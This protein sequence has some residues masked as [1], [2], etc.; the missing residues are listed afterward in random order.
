M[1][2][3]N[4]LPF[5]TLAQ[6]LPDVTSVLSGLTLLAGCQ[7]PAELQQALVIWLAELSD[8]ALVQLYLL[9]DSHSRLPLCC[10]WL[11]GA[12]SSDAER[13]GFT[14]PMLGYSLSQNAAL[15]MNELDSSLHSTS[16]L[17]AAPTPWRSL[18]CQPL[19]DCRQQVAGLLVLANRGRVINEALATQLAMISTIAM[20]QLKA[21]HQAD[22]AQ[23]TPCSVPTETM[24]TS[25]HGNFGLIGE[26]AAMQ[27][28]YRLVSKVLHNP[29]TVLL[30]GETG[31]GK[32][33]VARAIHDYG[34]R[35]TQPF[36]AQNC[37]ALPEQLLESELF[38]YRKGAFTGAN[39]DREGLFD[40][41]NGGTLFLDEIGD[42]PLA[43]QAKLLRVLQEGEVRPLGSNHSHRVD[44]RIIAA[45]HQNLFDQVE[46]GRFREDLYYRLSHFPIALPPLR[47]RGADI[48]QL[49]LHFTR[50]TCAFLQ[51]SDCR[52]SDSA[53]AYLASHRFPGNVRELKGLIARALLLCDGKVLLPEHLQLPNT[54]THAHRLTLREQL[55]KVERNLLSE[56]LQQ[57]NGNQTLTAQV[58]G[59]PRRTLLYRMQRLGLPPRPQ[60]QTE[61]APK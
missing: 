2:S 34:S 28:V 10:Q 60:R 12:L 31:T 55:D 17:P 53:L 25:E 7:R 44:V 19:L 11:D 20:A 9:D 35:R 14:D 33:L 61:S 21:M 54:P 47:E 23:Q 45:T 37:S 16:F 40:A 43:L 18:L 29:V 3:P 4:A 5:A 8:C 46:Q 38:G 51:R 22:L 48:R 36:I 27:G 15:H 50:E 58:L 32:E 41:A 57:H 30:G 42:M 6:P 13:D 24:T 49:A 56:A 39:Q 1:N 26:S 52:W 59:L